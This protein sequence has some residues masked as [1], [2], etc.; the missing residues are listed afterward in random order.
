V[1]ISFVSPSYRAASSDLTIAI[2]PLGLVELADEE[3]EVH[4]PRLNR[5]ASNWAFYLGHHWSYKREI[6]EPQITVNWAKAFSDFLTNFSLTNGVNFQSPHAT[7]AIVPQLLSTVWEEHQPQGK[8]AVMWELM[9]QGCTVPEAEALTPEGWKSLYEL[10]V[11]PDLPIATLHPET[12]AFEW[13]PFS[14]NV[15][16]Y[17][18]DLVQYEGQRINHVLTPEHDVWVQQSKTYTVRDG[19]R[20]DHG[21]KWR[22]RKAGETDGTSWSVRGGAD[23]FDGHLMMPTVP[24]SRQKAAYQ[25]PSPEAMVRFFGWWVSEGSAK[26]NGDIRIGQSLAVNPENFA[27]I[28]ALLDELQIGNSVGHAR[29]KHGEVHALYISNA[30]MANWLHQEFGQFDKERRLP[31]WVKGLPRPLLGLLL[32]T[33]RSGDGDSRFTRPRTWRYST[34]SQH[35]ADD[36]QE[37]AI[38]LGYLTTIT[39]EERSGSGWQ[40]M[41]RVHIDPRGLLSLP[42]AKAQ[43]YSGKVWCPTVPNG[44]WFMRLNGRAVVTGNSVSGDCFVKIAFEQEYADPAGNVHPSKIRILPLNSA[45]CLTP[46]TEVLTQRGWLSYEELAVGDSVLGLHPERDEIVWTPVEQ[47]NVFDWDGPMAKWENERFSVM[48]TADHRW[49]HQSARGKRSIR[50]THELHGLQGGGA[51]QLVVGG[52]TPMAFATV[53]KWD[54]DFVELVGWFVTEGH[55]HSGTGVPMFTQSEIENPEHAARI[56][57][58]TKMYGGSIYRYEGKATQWYV[59]RLKDD[60]M[61]AVGQQKQL[62]PELL[63]SL[64]YAQARLLYE[65]LLDG[66]GHRGMTTTFAQSDSGRM[67]GFQ[68]LAAMLGLRTQSRW[69][70]RSIGKPCGEAT[71]YKNR[72]LNLQNLQRSEEHYRGKVWCPTT[73]T[74][75]WLARRKGTTFWTG[76]CFPEYHPHDMSRLIRMKMKYRFWGCVDPDTQA[77]TRR[78]WKCYWE[79]EDE[80]EILTLNPVTDEIEWQSPSAVSVYPYKGEMHRWTGKVDA[81]TTPNHRWLAEVPHGRAHTRRTEREIVFSSVH[82]SQGQLVTGGG[83]P[84]AFADQPKWADELVETVGWYVTEGV[85][86]Y[87][88][89]GFHTIRISQKNTS[90]HIGRI[91]RLAAWW[92]DQDM[93]CNEWKPTAKGIIDFYFGKRSND[94]LE[95][96]APG[97]QLTPEFLCS[98]TYA[99]ARLLYETLLDGD[100]CRTRGQER[101]TQIDIFRVAGFQMLSG[102][103]GMR[104]R[105]FQEKVTNYQSRYTSLR[106]LVANHEEIIE[107]DGNVWCPTVPNSIWFAR[108]NGTTYWTGN[109]ALEGTR[110]VFSF[111]ELWTEDGMQ[112]FINDEMVESTENPLGMIPFVHIS[113]TKVPSSPWGLSDIQDITDLNRQYNETIT[114][115]SDIINYYAS[116]VTV[117]IGAKGNNLERG[118]KKVWAIPNEKASIQN[119]EL[120]SQ[121]EGPLQY[122]ETLK[123]K[124]HELVGIP[125]NAL[126]QDI[127]ISNT[128]GVALSLQFLPLVQKFHQKVTQYAAGLSRL[129]ELIIRTAAIYMPEMLVLDPSRDAPLEDGQLEVLDPADPLTFRNTVVFASPLPIDKLIALNEIQMEMGLGLESKRGAL[130]KLG[131]AYPAEKLEELLNELHQDALEQGALDLLNQQIMVLNSM[132]TGLPPGGP[133][134]GGS[135]QD[136]GGVT[137]AGGAD[138]SS[139]STVQP[140]APTLGDDPGVKSLMENLSTIA[141][142]TKQIQVRNPLNSEND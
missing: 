26:S 80:D 25:F 24:A 42:K 27:E 112:A 93:T 140:P 81:L 33:M 121:I 77:L 9:Q 68:M 132:L 30:G 133:E 107:Y 104:G 118:P 38:K 55:W 15:F 130:K 63:C 102:M 131:E 41:Y 3:F 59:R 7:E 99:Q 39:T 127:A 82:P 136:Q 62:T 128:S 34:V 35:L 116:P 43:H 64:T 137:S 51:G 16:D 57:R 86:H 4:G 129:N 48:S 84:M 71:V 138:V 13:Q 72:T 114:L 78:G 126:G 94:L 109:T 20:W 58:I 96:A 103:L 14:L 120:N 113:N 73:G 11:R 29:D 75:T 87:N 139:T 79:I 134:A 49:V 12:G 61:E 119:L 76:N 100:G 40:T 110:Q 123:E 19:K 6:G 106:E 2:S 23:Q 5:Y 124:M 18:G 98:L 53:P 108:R 115:I 65:T 21:S 66:D 74:G 50:Q 52:G 141:A 122:L 44:L 125:V 142:G 83:T 10:E 47:V 95:E 60:M 70:Q 92:R 54:D 1:A 31:A 90:P 101:W 85:D 22:K 56:D 45:F 46:D 105:Y 91:R 8:D 67:D 88:R 28:A 135:A 111:T 32:E 97:K 117:I 89:A 36:V 17:D 37:I 69:R